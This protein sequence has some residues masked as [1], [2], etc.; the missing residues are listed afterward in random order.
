MSNVQLLVLFGFKSHQSVWL[1][2]MLLDVLM[3]LLVKLLSK[4]GTLPFNLYPVMLLMLLGL[5]CN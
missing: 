4:P 1:L 5:L 2:M 3:V